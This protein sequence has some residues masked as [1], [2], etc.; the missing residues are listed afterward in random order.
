M[1]SNWQGLSNTAEVP[2][3]G[4]I[5]FLNYFVSVLM[6]SGHPKNITKV[7]VPTQFYYHG[8][9][10]KKENELEVPTQMQLRNE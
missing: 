2:N 9:S 10:P 6:I 4:I 5:S 1:L 7:V 3:N 8:L